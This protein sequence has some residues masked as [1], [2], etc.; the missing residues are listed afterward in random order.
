MESSNQH[1]LRGDPEELQ[2]NKKRFST[3][4]FEDAAMI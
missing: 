1:R 4:I 3:E 2:Q